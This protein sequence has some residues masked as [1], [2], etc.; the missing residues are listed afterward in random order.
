MQHVPTTNARMCDVS[1]NYQE[2][3]N[4]K[5]ESISASIICPVIPQ[6]VILHHE[7]K[8]AEQTTE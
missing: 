3:S 4:L 2:P 6:H 7:K 8:C 1:E 5:I